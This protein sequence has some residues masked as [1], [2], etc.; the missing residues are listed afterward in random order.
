MGFQEFFEKKAKQ[1]AKF[2]A[3]M[4]KKGVDSVDLLNDEIVKKTVVIS[5]APAPVP[6]APISSNAS[7]SKA[8]A[9]QGMSEDEI[10]AQ[11]MNMSV[12]EYRVAFGLP[13]GGAPAAPVE[14]PAVALTPE[15]EKAAKLAA[16]ANKE[17]DKMNKLTEFVSTPQF[18][19]KFNEL[20]L[21]NS[22]FLDAKEVK[23]LCKWIHISFSSEGAEPKTDQ[24]IE[25]EAKRLIRAIDKNGDGNIAMDE[26]RKHYETKAQKARKFA[27]NQAKK[28]ASP[29]K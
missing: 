15:E 21:D 8:D 26:F 16:E 13:A 6:E 18:S 25:K 27:A 23:E 22:G 10:V 5:D 3:A 28:N 1:A 2:A 9:L 12:E 29:S 20:D 7:P 11:S 24:E 19:E 17:T 14:A 4:N